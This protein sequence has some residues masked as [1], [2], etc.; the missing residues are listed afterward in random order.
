ML[1]GFSELLPLTIY[2]LLILL[3]TGMFNL[4]YN[5]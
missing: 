3:M 2:F 4:I 5:I 1:V